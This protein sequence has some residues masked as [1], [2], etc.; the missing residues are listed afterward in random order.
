M[1]RYIFF[2]LDNTLYEEKNYILACYNEIAKFINKKTSISISSL[3]IYKI[4][5][6]NGDRNVF[7]ILLKD[8]NIANIN[9]QQL[10]D[11]YQS[12]NAPVQLYPNVRTVLL[13]LSKQY[14]L[15]ILTNGGEKTQNN[16]INCLGIRCLFDNIIITGKHL[17]KEFWKPHKSAFRLIFEF[18]SCNSLECIYIGDSYNNDVL[19][20]KNAGIFPIFLSNQYSEG[21]HQIEDNQIWVINEFSSIR[22]TIR[23]INA[24]SS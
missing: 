8:Y 24:Y 5:E 11:I 4:R 2:D 19:G 14:S 3:D 23:M 13:D 21:L 1:I 17:E 9:F 7:Q 12:F 15:G 20:A 16:K 6:K 22:Q 10:I 18:C